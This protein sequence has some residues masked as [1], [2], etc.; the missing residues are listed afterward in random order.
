MR[1]PAS[2]AAALLLAA[3]GG[4]KEGVIL[5]T[6]RHY[7]AEL[8]ATSAD[9]FSAPDGLVPT[10]G[11]FLFADEGDGTVRLWSG[12]GDARVLADRRAGLSTP[13]DLAVGRDGAIWFS[14]DDAG[15][16]WRI[17]A[18]RTE[19]LFG[20]A[21]GLGSTEGLTLAPDGSALVGDGK[22]HQVYR[23]DPSGKLS[24][25]VG[26]DA[27]IAKPESLAFDDE[28]QLY[29]ADNAEHVLYRL[30]PDGRLSRVIERRDGF[31]PESIAWGA[32]A[33]F[34]T[35]SRHGKLHRYTPER[36]L[37]TVAVFGGKLAH[38]AGLTVDPAGTV[39]V[40]VQQDLKAGRG[41]LLRLFRRSGRMASAAPGRR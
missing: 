30:A 17:A 10:A 4:D 22:S 27:G 12:R 15:G 6:D 9:G 41:Y 2:L 26:A 40:T 28:G 7:G 38:V 35:D 24:V 23:L 33:L 34:I 31:S 8:V 18:G 39:H 29:I 5:L 3:C 1:L 19:R 14:D 11:G 20:P 16:L 37:E 21:Q 13:E 32:G 36:G 25:L